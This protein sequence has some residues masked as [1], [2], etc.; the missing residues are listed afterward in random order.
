MT[1]RGIIRGLRAVSFRRS[2]AL[3]C[4][5]MF[6]C[7]PIIVA[8]TQ[9]QMQ[10]ETL[11]IPQSASG[12]DAPDNPNPMDSAQKRTED[13]GSVLSASRIIAI[14]Q[15]NPEVIIEIKS[16]VADLAQAKGIPTQADGITD[17]QLFSQISNSVELRINITHLLEARGYISEQDVENESKAD[18]DTNGNQ[19]AGS[20]ADSTA[21]SVLENGL[22]NP[23]L[24]NLTG[25]LDDSVVLSKSPN[26]GS[27]QSPSSAR[28]EN[29]RGAQKPQPNITD[30]PKSLHR[31]APYNLLSLRDL[32]TQ[33][34]DSPQQLK[35]FG[36]DVFIHRGVTGDNN[37][38]TSTVGSLPLDIPL[39][40]DYVLGPGD[41]LLI[42]LWGGVSQSFTRPISREG[43]ITLPEAGQV[44]VAGLTLG[45]AQSVISGALQP[46]FRNAHVAV[47]MARLRTIR[48][49]VVGDVQ[50]PGAYDISSLASPLSA[51]YAA[52]GPTAIGSL[53]VMH[54]MRNGSSIG[55]IDL[56]DFLLH[57]TRN[58]DDHL[59]GGDT[60]LVPPAGP[61]VAIY[62][63]V[64]RP[65]IYELLK[66]KT[67]AAGLENAGGLTVAA[68]LSHITI[69]RIVANEHREIIRVEDSAANGLTNETAKF[70][71]VD[72]KDGDR[73]RVGTVLPSTE[74][75]VY[76]QGHVARPGKLA[77]RDGMHL[78]DVLKSYRD[79]LPEPASKGEIVRLVAPDL[80]PE[81]INFNIPDILIGNSN[82]PLQPF[83]TIRVF[84][85]YERDSPNVTIQGEV[86]HPGSYPMFDGMSAAQLVR[87]AG[88][89]KRDAS[90]ED[91]DLISYHVVNDSGVTIERR[92][93]A[94]G[95]AVL[96][97]DTQ[98]DSPLQP[99]DV[100]TIHQMTGWE[101]IGA[102]ILIQ[103]EVAHPGSYGFKEGEHLSD[104]LRR[105]GGFR[106]TAYPEGAVLTR[107]EVKVLEE[108]S[109]EELI[110]QIE[111]SSAAARMSQTVTGGDQA[112]SLQLIQL[113]QDRV[114]SQLRSQPASGRLVI[115]IDSSIDKW[116]GTAADIEVRRGDVLR[117]PKRPGF[118]LISGQ[119]YNTSAITFIAGKSASWYLERAGGATTTA[120]R[121]EIFVIRA[122]GSVVGRRSGGSSVLST[123]L[124]P[125]DVIVV[126]QKIIGASVVW[127]NILGVGQIAASL[128]IAA[129]VSGL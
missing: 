129:A 53:R 69:E 65:A 85:R 71:N 11:P 34:P 70:A 123:K 73:I 5:V 124:E 76:L 72:L 82:L 77:Y 62:G 19:P 99:G 109:R 51:L 49:Y 15:R 118:V 90:L 52:G 63:A 61:Q 8:Q 35:R 38:L 102:S 48:I 117:I 80:H 114:L 93:I 115:G 7:A 116:A 44:Q 3:G 40:P 23:D 2:S 57:G 68:E 58:T 110:R 43:A 6:C 113:Q 31:P 95:A 66:E 83:D 103:G 94:I 64:K 28:N 13:P 36:A 126:P 106:A 74:Q 119:V 104:V 56:Y 75:V 54:H 101:D 32:Y 26:L 33:S 55:D 78:A 105:A 127:R 17:E 50:R 1:V 100:L 88:G 112:A 91:A 9:P 24:M 25:S 46:Q 121:K 96:R 89:F 67:L 84:G 98:A 18:L 14:A 97:N 30:E 37:R 59:Q 108:K 27:P 47:T 21:D 86:Q 4:L 125:G 128:A 81:T 10:P 122:N 41:E 29:P 111:T 22:K 12:M 42:S 45:N 79:L 39:G 60:L 87:A 92:T 120:N 16:L 107:P 20:A